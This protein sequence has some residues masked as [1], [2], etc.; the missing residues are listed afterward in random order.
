[1]LHWLD[2]P[3]ATA[4]QFAFRRL[5]GEPVRAIVSV[6]T[7]AAEQSPLADLAHD[8]RFERL[9]LGPL[10]V[11]VLHRVLA[12]ALGRTFSRPTLVRIA[13]ASGGNPLYALEIGRL[14]DRGT[15]R[16]ASPLPVPQSLNAL[17]AARVRALPARTREA[18]LRAAALA[19]PDATL[20][21]AAALGPAEEAGLV[22]LL[23]GGRI[24]FV[25]PPFA[26]AVYSSAALARTRGTHD[27]VAGAIHHP[28]ERAPAGAL[29]S[30]GAW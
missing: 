3:S 12:D 5:G 30:D 6:R 17:V 25:H 23:A 27:A 8:R 14:L 26:S 29:S 9:E 24:E 18:L 28:E 10:S 7:E 4:L 16:D 2:P 22:R 19:R 15:E 1:D 21:D 13:R 20:V 11:A